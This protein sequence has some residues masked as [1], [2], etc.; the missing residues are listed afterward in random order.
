MSKRTRII[1]A[2]LAVVVLGVVVAVNVTKDRRNRIN[3]QTQKVARLDL[4]STVTASGE[5]KPRKYVNVSSN[6][7]GRITHLLV[8]EGERV[9]R[10]QVLARIDST[11]LE[12][13]TRQSEAGVSAQKADVDRAQADL[14]AAKLSFERTQRMHKD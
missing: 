9:R 3:V 11:R 13:N 12:A 14:E 2:V 4:V 5:V 1:V 8:K 10:G 7:S 6:V